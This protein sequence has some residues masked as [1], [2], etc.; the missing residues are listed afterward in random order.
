MSIRLYTLDLL[1]SCTFLNILIEIKPNIASSSYFS[2]EC[3]N[4]LHVSSKRSSIKL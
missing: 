3:N 2:Y 4:S 1:F